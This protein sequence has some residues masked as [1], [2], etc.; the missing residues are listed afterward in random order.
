MTEI[1]LN[2]WLFDLQNIC[3]KYCTRVFNSYSPSSKI[4]EISRSVETNMDKL[5][6]LR[7]SFPRQSFTF[8]L[9]RAVNPIHNAV[10][11]LFL[12]ISI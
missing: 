10:L 3:L 2:E 9:I 12:S 4:F 8:L 1:T 7:P 5:F 6:A 11:M